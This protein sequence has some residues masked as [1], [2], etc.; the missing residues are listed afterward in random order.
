MLTWFW[1][2]LS[3]RI[4]PEKQSKKIVNTDWKLEA[5]EDFRQWLAEIPDTK[6]ASEA[7]SLDSCDLFTLLSEFSALR[8]EIRVQNRQ[9][10]KS[11]SNIE[12]AAIVFQDAAQLFKS[13]SQ[14]LDMFHENIR[15]ACEK[16]SA[17]NF[18]DVRDALVRGKSAIE[19]IVENKSLFRPLPKG[20]DGVMEGYEMAIRR[21][22]KALAALNIQPVK[23]V[24]E[25]FDPKTMKAIGKK[26]G[27]ELGSGI[28]IEEVS[29]GFIR[30]D[31][32][33]KTAHVIVTQ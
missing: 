13:K 25:P 7:A 15:L 23:T 8:Q 12:D 11:L 16:Q 32:I 9:Q 31:E 3:K 21:M 17:V 19:K 27:S 26:A 2:L 33:I 29:G 28:V 10:A 1:R 30:N 14:Q 6:P 20:M 4:T 24:G 22:D 5:L 18:F